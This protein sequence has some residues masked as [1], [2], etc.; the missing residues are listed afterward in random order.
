MLSY[1]NYSMFFSF[2]RSFPTSSLFKRNFVFI[3]LF[4]IPVSIILINLI[5]V[6]VVNA[7]ASEKNPSPCQP[8]YGG[9]ESCVQTGKITINKTVQ[10][11]QTLQYVDNLNADSPKYNPGQTVQFQIAVKN[12][13]NT[14][15]KNI[16][17]KD[18][19]PQYMDCASEGAGRCNNATKIIAFT[20]DDLNANEIRIYTLKGKIASKSNLPGDK[21]TICLVNQGIAT[22]D[23]QTSQDNSQFCIQK[24]EVPPA[25]AQ[26]TNP[27]S[28][29]GGLPVYPPSHTKTTPPTGPE[30]ITLL[31]LFASGLFG[32][33]LHK[34]SK[35]WLK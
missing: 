7:A 30:T 29:K 13:T 17:I 27:N 6:T 9:G 4:S 35:K 1:P 11:P 28:T 20:I 15:V 32:F 34:K 31:G 22:Q 16:E 5:L 26:P 23:K 2:L 21:E 3:L 14:S 24:N 33:M 25:A 12:T 19:L 18:R 8:I 10:D